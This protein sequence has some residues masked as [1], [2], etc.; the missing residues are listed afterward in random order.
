MAKPL[1]KKKV[2]KKNTEKPPLIPEKYQDITF[3][4]ILTLA[5]FIFFA[6]AIAGGGFNEFDNVSSL[7]FVPYLQK[8]A[9][10]GHYPLWVPYIFSGMPG[11]A[12]LL[13]TGERMWDIVPWLFFA[14]SGF[15]KTLF[16]NDT[17][18]I[19]IYYSIYAAG[20][21][22]FMRYKKQERVIAF[23]S[24]FAAVFSTW[25]IT[26]VMIGHNTKPVVLALF[27]FV[28]LFM[29]KL[30]EKFSLLYAVLLIFAVHLMFEGGHLQMIFYGGIA[31]ALYL[32]FE[33]ISRL[34][35]KTEP[36]KIVRVAGLLVIAAGF[37]YLMSADRYFSVQEY[38]PY[39]TRGSA[40]IMKTANQHQTDKGG[41]DYEYATMWSY[42][43]MESWTFLV[44]GYFGH[45]LMKWAPEGAPE[46][47]AQLI[48]TYWGS[49]ETEDSPPY[50][51]ILVLAL[52]VLGFVFYRKD[53]FV[54]FLLVLIVF[55]WLL[56][57]GKNLSVVYNIFY[58]NFPNFNKFRAPSMAFVLIHF[59]VPL[60]AGYGLAGIF[61]MRKEFPKVDMKPLKYFLYASGG[62]LALGLVFITLFK[63][64]YISAVSNSRTFKSLAQ[65][66]NPQI[67]T[68]LQN[69]VWSVMVSDWMIGGVILVLGGVLFYM[70]VQG[71]LS[72]AAL[73]VSLLVLF[74]FDL[75][76]VDYRRMNVAEESVQEE[77]F[78]RKADVYNYIKQDKDIYRVADFSSNPANIP[79]Y[80]LVENINGY[81]A[82]K[83][84]VYQDVLD[85]AQQNSSTSYLFNP[86]LWNIL[87]V[88][89]II[90]NRPFGE[91]FQPIYTSQISGD[92]V[93]LN[94]TGLPRAF[95][96]KKAEKAKQIDILKHLKE[97]DFN[98]LET[99]WIE[100]DLSQ[101]VEPYDSTVNVKILEHENEYIKIEADA[102]GNNF[103]FISEVYYPVGWKA[104][105]D[106]NETPIIKSNYAFRGVIVPKGKHTIE[107]KF[108]SSAF[109]QGKTISIILNIAMVLA[110]VA[111]VFFEKR[112]KKDNRQD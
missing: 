11:Y 98:P 57:M 31:F 66:A 45:G 81:H 6:G 49:K 26:W 50:M 107:M 80:F 87:N 33:F 82:A 65:N 105:I 13:V 7:S 99:V 25:V 30:R 92:Y 10:D 5:V 42:S 22:L 108:T 28:F 38:T 89:F 61:K 37:S 27:P 77:V 101:T 86:F 39:S 72:K 48:S 63:D 100:K 110:L 18:R 84:R 16:G 62:F 103:L 106:G 34:V 85:V 15:F 2:Q 73:I 70:F 96:V 52:A 29:E 56:G 8:A 74:A 32:I 51:G 88:K 9:A 111:G 20:I 24:A 58:Y 64:S 97:G 104:Y 41:N 69:F 79:A 83:L 109:E 94:S 67:L 12:A 78:Q 44:P 14:F 47:N 3:I 91:G 71:K 75:W 76:H 93:Y 95:F 53:T 40:P 112:K 60:L 59:A 90:T 21:Y 55:A 1:P 35:K 36:L 17:A 23:L 102:S 68:D 43:P 54:Q 4:L 19:A 46:D